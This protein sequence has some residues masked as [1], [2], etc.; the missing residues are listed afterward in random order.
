M[1]K[2]DFTQSTNQSNDNPFESD[3]R[4]MQIN[5]ISTHVIHSTEVLDF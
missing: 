2:Y 3:T 4:V 5:A 1:S